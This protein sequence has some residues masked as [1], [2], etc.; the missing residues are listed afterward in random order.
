M[1]QAKLIAIPVAFI[2]AMIL[3]LTLAACSGEKEEV[4]LSAA[5]ETAMSERLAPA[6][7]VAMA[8]EV[9]SAP[10]ASNGGS[11]S[12]EEVYNGT[13]T[14][15]HASGAAGAPI[16]GSAEQWADRIGKGMDTLYTS[17]I[18][19]ING[20]PP[21]GLCFDCSD[22]ELKAAVDYMVESSK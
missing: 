8:S 17:A 4:S 13:C 16:T 11:R 10:T 21:K 22:A 18:S 5:Q 15:C 20:M 2:T 6:G 1:K 14:T 19:G 9:A 3:V 12:G 7:E